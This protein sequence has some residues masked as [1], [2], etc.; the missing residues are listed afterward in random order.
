MPVEKPLQVPGCACERSI[1]QHSLIKQWC[2]TRNYTHLQCKL[3]WGL[4]SV[5]GVYLKYLIPCMMV[6]YVVF[7]F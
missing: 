6:K 7:V 5:G 2:G 1:F 3:R 4:D